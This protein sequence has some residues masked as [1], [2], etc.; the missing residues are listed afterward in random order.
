MKTKNNSNDC[1][2]KDKQTNKHN[3]QER[4]ERKTHD[5]KK[6]TH[7]DDAKKKKTHTQTINNFVV[8]R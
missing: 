8:Q 2:E 4:K 7:T 3:I 6:Q 5:V 1:I